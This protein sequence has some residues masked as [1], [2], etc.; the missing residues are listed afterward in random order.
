M[1]I[2]YADGKTLEGILLYRSESEIRVAVPG[3]EDIVEFKRVNEIW[4]SEDCEPA[5]IDFGSPARAETGE[6]LS[7][8]DFICSHE[9]A[10]HLIHLL[11]NGDDDDIECGGPAASAAALSPVLNRRLMLN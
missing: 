9:L 6:P 1:I 11:L 4:V 2:R 5:R 10:A 3:C 8:A 7:P